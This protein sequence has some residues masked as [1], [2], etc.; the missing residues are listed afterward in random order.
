M[1]RAAFADRFGGTGQEGLRAIARR[2]LTHDDAESIVAGLVGAFMG[3]H[4]TDAEVEEQAAAARRARPARPV[5]V[6]AEEP[7]KETRTEAPTPREPR[8]REPREQREPRERESRPMREPREARVEAPRAEA[9]RIEARAPEAPVEGTAATEP[10]AEGEA[11]RRRRRERP[12]GEAPRAPSEARSEA[13]TIR[14]VPSR[15]LPPREAREPREPRQEE[16]PNFATLFLNIGRREG[17]RVGDVLRLFE[18]RAAL[19][20]DQLGR[21]R[22]RDRH[23]FV[24]IAHDQVA[25]VLESLAGARFG[26]R[27]L[28]SEVARQEKPVEVTEAGEVAG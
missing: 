5:T 8:A 25:R 10:D 6:K 12:E 26:E 13:R 27:D 17:V 14:D 18:D 11:R 21:I 22:I 15:E 16:D 7:A 9:P 3:A 28:V 1:I 4:G 24:G 19:T 20:K 2:V 23:T